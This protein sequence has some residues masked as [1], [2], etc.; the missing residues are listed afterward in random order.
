MTS[1]PEI[2]RVLFASYDARQIET[3]E[4]VCLRISQPLTEWLLLVNI[5]TQ[6]LYALQSKNIRYAY[7]V[8]TGKNGVGQ[9][10]DSGQ[11]PL[12]L[13]CIGSKIGADANSWAIFISRTT[14]GQIAT[15]GVGKNDIVGR[16]L[17]LHGLEVG[18]N[19]GINSE[20][21]IVDTYKRCIYIHG[22]SDVFNRLL[23]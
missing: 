9:E 19:Q 8:S 5:N 13:H 20:G 21:K 7:P 4:E 18:F 14:M 6:R 2:N 12:G 3:V 23:A 1:V 16:I 10:L 17:V 15:A 22:T 11:T